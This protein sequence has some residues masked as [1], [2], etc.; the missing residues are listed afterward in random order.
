MITRPE[1]WA[2]LLV[3]TNR[4]GEYRC[5]DCDWT[6]RAVTWAGAKKAAMRHWVETHEEREPDPGPYRAE[7]CGCG[8]SAC[9]A[10]HVWSV[11]AVQGVRFT[12]EQ[13]EAVAELLNQG[14]E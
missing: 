5:R 14:I 3:P 4:V 2:E 7:P 13:A 10:W 12:R 6:T 11:T 1:Y 9:K 8:Y